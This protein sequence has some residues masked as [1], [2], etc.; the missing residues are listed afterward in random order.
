M[1]NLLR[2]WLV[3]RNGSDFAAPVYVTIRPEE[4][5]HMKSKMKIRVNASK[6]HVASLLALLLIAMLASPLVAGAQ[7]PAATRFLGTIAAISGTTLTVKVD[8]N[9]DRQVVVPTEASSNASHPEK[10]I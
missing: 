9:G 10:R 8:G 7:A 1:H 2:H 3:Y 5:R 4:K 6:T